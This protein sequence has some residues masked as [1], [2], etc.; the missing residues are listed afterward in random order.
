MELILDIKLFV[1]ISFHI[2]KTQSKK[3]Q[4]IWL[5]YSGWPISTCSGLAPSGTS[6]VILQVL[7][8]PPY[9]FYRIL[10]LIQKPVT[11][12][13][14]LMGRAGNPKLLK[15]NMINTDVSGGNISEQCYSGKQA[16]LRRHGTI[17][18]G[19]V[20]KMCSCGTWGHGLVVN[21]AVLG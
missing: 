18:P 21:M 8:F 5:D 17:I 13:S 1:E 4:G 19:N 14:Y 16:A 11:K 2:A 7:C 15:L 10:E 3:L 6:Q 9:K 12:W 20:R